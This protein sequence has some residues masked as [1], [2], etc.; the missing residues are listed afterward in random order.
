MAT[1]GTTTELKRRF[2]ALLRNHG[3]EIQTDDDQSFTDRL[4]D[5][6][7]TIITELVARGF[8]AAQIATWSRRKEFEYNIAICYLAG[9]F[10]L[11]Q[12]DGEEWITE[13]FCVADQ[14]EE[15]PIIDENDE[16]LDPGTPGSVALELIDVEELNDDI[17]DAE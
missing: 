11:H 5:S 17:I 9:D 2:K 7:N 15:I 8:T 4:Q 12:G 13:K 14:L 6:H 10:A 1:W 3:F 16:E